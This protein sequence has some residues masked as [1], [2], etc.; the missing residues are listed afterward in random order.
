MEGRCR[1]AEGS[2][3]PGQGL[4][5]AGPLRDQSGCLTGQTVRS[6]CHTDSSCLGGGPRGGDG[7][8]YC[9]RHGLPVPLLSHLTDRLMSYLTEY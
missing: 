1:C 3:W 6:R 5:R 4:Q 7:R 2:V 9:N 8:A